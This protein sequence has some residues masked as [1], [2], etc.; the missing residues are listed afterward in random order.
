MAKFLQD[1]IEEIALERKEKLKAKGE[2][3]TPT[4]ALEFAQFMKKV[5]FFMSFSRYFRFEVRADTC[6]M[7]KS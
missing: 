6:R 3:D 4:Q 2:T 7:Q 5:I 1:T